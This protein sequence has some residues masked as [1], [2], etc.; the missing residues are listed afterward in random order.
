MTGS[1]VACDDDASE[2]NKRSLTKAGASLSPT[3]I[4]A[5]GSPCQLVYVKPRR[6]ENRSRPVGVPQP[7]EAGFR[8][9][10]SLRP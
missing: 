3:Y 9:R 8:M 10:L 6:L 5:L 7:R 2:G 4:V 1:S